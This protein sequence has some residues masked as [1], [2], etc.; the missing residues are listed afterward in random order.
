MICL[1]AIDSSSGFFTTLATSAL[2]TQKSPWRERPILS[3]FERAALKLL[4]TATSNTWVMCVVWGGRASNT[5]LL[6]WA[7][8]IN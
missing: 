5:T 8:L 3:S 4:K 1:G 7:H 2:V 6:V